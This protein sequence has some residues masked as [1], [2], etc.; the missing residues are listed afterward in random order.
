MVIQH[1]GGLSGDPS[2]LI[3]TF[4][5]HL[6]EQD[7]L[8]ERQANT[9]DVAERCKLVDQMPAILAEDLPR[10]SLYAPE[11][12]SFVDADNDDGFAYTARLPALPGDGQQ[13]QSGFGQRR[14]G[15]RRL[16]GPGCV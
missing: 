7:Q 2:S 13:A 11:Q 14:S 16:I 1:F 10:I 5:L 6:H 3:P 9:V 15:A 8:A 4:N 12:V